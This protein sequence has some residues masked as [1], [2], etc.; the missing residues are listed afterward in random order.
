MILRG[1]AASDG[2]G[3]GRAVRVQAQ[4][5][6]HSAVIYGGK[7]AERARLREATA[8]FHA[9]TA[10][11]AQHIRAQ[12]GEKA[13]EILAGQSMMLD[14]PVLQSQLAELIDAGQCA[15]GA[16]D[17]VCTM[18]AEMFAGTDDALIGQRAADVRDIRSRMLAILL[19]A[20][21]ADVRRLPAGSVLV[22]RELTPSMTVG[23]DKEHVAAILTETGGAAS[24][25]AILARTLELPAVLG[26]SGIMEQLKDGDRI[27]VDGSQ[28]VAL[29]RP[30]PSALDK[31]L[32]KQEAFRREKI[33][34]AAYRDRPTMDAQGRRV[35]LCANIGSPADAGAAAAAGA[36]GIGLFRTEFLFM[37]RDSLPGE[38]EQYTAYLA[39][40]RIMAGREVVIRT[41]DV[42][43]D[44][45][46]ACLPMAREDNP[47]L[48]HRAIRY[49]LDNPE[50]CKVQFRAL[51]R[52]GAEGRNIKILLPLV[53]S[54]EE[55]AAARTLLEA[56]K[57]ELEAEGLPYCGD[58]HLGLMV[59]TPAAALIADLLARECDFFSIGTNDLT[60]Y[61]MAADRGNVQV[62]SLY[63]P[64]HPAVLRAIRKVIAAAKEADIPVG[65]CGEAAADPR[66]TP[67]LLA[68]GLDEFSVSPSAIPAIRAQVRRWSAARATQV[69]QQAMELTTAADVER[70]LQSVVQGSPAS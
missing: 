14:D 43:G 7:E 63:T 42:G 39:V 23:L 31:Y 35:L 29:I 66:F 44:K 11:M 5:L 30:D 13:S 60:Q 10:A 45:A 37:D 36:E 1:I 65:M 16:V 25:A 62:N 69:A 40:S 58:T 48:G 20:S 46:I 68:W 19:G 34:L 49:C 6:D 47:F 57:A 27:I 9:E 41:L 3:I 28:G 21:R 64:F 55:V 61:V 4:N 18:Y 67:L 22:A 56:C 59:E 53:T 51:L 8:R 50:L 38:E 33:L 52:A 32:E 12:A 15:E 2:I 70:F 54:L 17:Q 26:V 24:H